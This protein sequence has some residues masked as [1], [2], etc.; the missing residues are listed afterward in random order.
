MLITAAFSVF[1]WDWSLGLIYL[2]KKGGIYPLL[3]PH[4]FETLGHL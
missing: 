1:A 2:K 4:D 3:C